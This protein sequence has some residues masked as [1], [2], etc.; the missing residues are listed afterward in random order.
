MEFCQRNDLTRKELIEKARR[1]RD[2][3]TERMTICYPEAVGRPPACWVEDLIVSLCAFRVAD[4]PLPKGQLG[5]CDVSNRLVLMNSEMS[6]FVGETV[7]LNHLRPSTLGHELGH[8]RLHADE[9]TSQFI[10]KYGRWAQYRDPRLIQREN[11]ADVY[12]AVFL[13]PGGMLVDH[14]RGREIYDAWRAHRQIRPGW[15]ERIIRELAA[16][17]GV[18]SSLMRRSL[19][20]RG[21]VD[22]DGK[23]LVIGFKSTRK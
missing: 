22:L 19:V 5:L 1:D 2:E 13:V 11:E 23:K 7:D 3:L 20:M 6:Q 16:D 4:Y 18:T 21:W 10:T 9:L 8:I 12:A 17:F 15:L 14:A